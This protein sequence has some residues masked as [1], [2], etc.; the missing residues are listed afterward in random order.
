[1]V[2]LSILESCLHLSAFSK[3]LAS[4]DCHG[5]TRFARVPRAEVNS[6]ALW[7]NKPPCDNLP[8]HGTNLR[9]LG[10]FTPKW[11]D[12]VLA[13][14]I[15]PSRH[16]SD[17]CKQ[18]K[19]N[20]IRQNRFQQVKRDEYIATTVVQSCPVHD[21]YEWA[22][23]RPA[24][25]AKHAGW[26]APRGA[27]GLSRSEGA[28]RAEYLD[29]LDF[30]DVTCQE[31]KGDE[32]NCEVAAKTWRAGA[33]PKKAPT[34]RN[35]QAALSGDIFSSKLH[36]SSGSRARAALNPGQLNQHWSTAAVRYVGWSQLVIEPK[37]VR[38]Y[39]RKKKRRTASQNPTLWVPK[40]KESSNKFI[41]S[42]AFCKS[43]FDCP[44]AIVEICLPIGSQEV[45]IKW[46]SSPNWADKQPAEAVWTCKFVG[47]V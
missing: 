8:C 42:L 38:N 13:D 46:S 11:N 3:L 4:P 5:S 43:L 31:G 10:H 30:K 7:T 35:H 6:L 28:P 21:R 23:H 29:C 17:P 12:E 39:I 25:H 37:K 47:I 19:S 14:R 32:T 24:V 45:L 16:G 2:G 15:S 34:C 44:D 36:G 40:P 20:G 26:R 22:G 41:F 9:D 18:P 1:M 33:K 27:S